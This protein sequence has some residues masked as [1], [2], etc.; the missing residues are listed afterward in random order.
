MSS[1]T[2]INDIKSIVDGC[3]IEHLK[4]ISTKDDISA[5]S[6]EIQLLRSQNV[7][8]TG[9]LAAVESYCESLEKQL[10]FLHEK[11]H[12]NSVVLHLPPDEK[13]DK[14]SQAK[15][16]CLSLLD[17][18]VNTQL[19]YEKSQEFVNRHNNKT[20]MVLKFN[21]KATAQKI[22]KAAP[23]LK[24]TG[25]VVHRE[26]SFLYRNKRKALFELRSK[27]LAINP[28]IRIL[29]RGSKLKIS[30]FL[31]SHDSLRGLK[32]TTSTEL[33]FVKITFGE[34]AMCFF[35]VNINNN[36]N[37]PR[38]SSVRHKNKNQHGSCPGSSQ[39]LYST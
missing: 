22:L 15:Q 30:D 2:Q 8:L 4:N 20:T 6:I 32:I 18:D 38:E 19:S 33:S 9:R 26:Q 12:E 14:D 23:K 25:V 7:H 29:I 31:F 1:L 27:L 28:N 5:I 34:E 16:T 36:S 37:T 17:L 24:G 35:D 39:Y 13:T 3:L 11:S 21:D 10:E